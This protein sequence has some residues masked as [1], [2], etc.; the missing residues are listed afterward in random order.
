MLLSLQNLVM[1]SILE[2]EKTC[3]VGF[4][5]ELMSMMRGSPPAAIACSNVN[6]K[7]DSVRILML[8]DQ[9]LSGRRYGT[10]TCDC[11]PVF[12]IRFHPKQSLSGMLNL[13][14]IADP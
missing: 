5:G 9:S 4:E 7:D 2:E 1:A 3:P 13:G 11:M 8:E 6:F 14:L 10:P 12:F